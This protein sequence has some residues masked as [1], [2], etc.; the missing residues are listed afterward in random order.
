MFICSLE[1]GVQYAYANFICTL[2]QPD[3]ATV[4]WKDIPFAVLLLIDIAAKVIP[5]TKKTPARPAPRSPE[6]E[7]PTECH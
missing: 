2:N 1:I 6:N 4:R 3:T 7:L 5:A